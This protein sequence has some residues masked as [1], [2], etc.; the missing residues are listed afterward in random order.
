MT[1][2]G[3]SNDTVTAKFI[4]SDLRE[5]FHVTPRSSKQLIYRL[6]NRS[7]LEL[8]VDY[9][10]HKKKYKPIV[11]SAKIQSLKVAIRYIMSLSSSKDY[12]CTSGWSLLKLLSD[13]E[14]SQKSKSISKWSSVESDN[15]EMVGLYIKC[16]D[17]PTCY[18]VNAICQALHTYIYNLDAII[19]K[20]IHQ[21]W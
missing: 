10:R 19:I 5:F 18:S 17:T 21:Q 15:N 3:G 1:K 2:A 13:L 9:L 14:Q 12:H 20:N 16:I 4:S 11:T 6:L 7:N 8:F